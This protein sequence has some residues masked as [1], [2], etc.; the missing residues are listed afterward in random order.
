MS[1]SLRIDREPVVITGVGAVSPLGSAF[2]EIADNLLAGR[3]GVRSV[4]PGEY[5]REPV[6]FAAPVTT[7]PAP[8]ADTCGLSPE[9]F[10]ALDRLEQLCLAPVAAALQDFVILPWVW[11]EW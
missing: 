2:D 11:S 10:Y 6:Q 4:D 7:I 8:D 3:S 1:V 9:S 5:A